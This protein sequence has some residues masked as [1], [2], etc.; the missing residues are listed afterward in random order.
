MSILTIKGVKRSGP[1]VRITDRDCADLGVSTGADNRCRD[2]QG[3]PKNSLLVSD[4]IPA[5]SV[6]GVGSVKLLA[7]CYRIRFGQFFLC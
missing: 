3:P 1:G 4:L 6:T 7:G 2:R 5:G